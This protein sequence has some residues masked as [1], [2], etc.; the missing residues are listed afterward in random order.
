MGKRLVALGHCAACTGVAAGASWEPIMGFLCSESPVPLRSREHFPVECLVAY[1]AFQLSC[2]SG[3]FRTEL[4]VR[5]HGPMVGE[6]MRAF[7]ARFA[8]LAAGVESP[9]EVFP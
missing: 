1:G 7:D 5:D 6:V 9:V 2:P 3:T 8:S 4:C